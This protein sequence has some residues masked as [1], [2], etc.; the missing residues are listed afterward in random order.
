[1]LQV[2]RAAG[3][4][5]LVPL[6]FLIIALMRWKGRYRVLRKAQIRRR[7]KEVTSGREPVIICANH[8]TLIDSVIM[9]WAL[10]S[11][12][13]YICNY[14]LFSWNLPASENV[15][16]HLSWRIITYLSKCIG[17]E[18]LGGAQHSDSI[19]NKICFLLKKR[20]LIM[21]FPEG[22]RSRSGRVT[23][24]AVTYGIGK[25]LQNLPVCRVLCVYL[26]GRGQYSYSDFPKRGE[27]FDLDM[28]L[29]KPL[30]DKNGLR[31]ARDLS[32]QVGAKL[33]ELED[34]YFETHESAP[35]S[36]NQYR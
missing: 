7:F 24:E 27:V 23:P 35:L 29:F 32:R 1:M 28:E 12:Q 25:I 19:L 16:K 13:T 36:A 15:K 11:T 8:L 18:R 14:R 31:G 2:Q 3:W 22:T 34:R 4:L 20:E 6:S 5:C 17:V 30:T 10:A 9:L 33:K 21:L 26:R